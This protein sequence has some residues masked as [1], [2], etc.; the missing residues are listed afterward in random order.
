MMTNVKSDAAFQTI[1]DILQRS[2]GVIMFT[3]LQWIPEVSTLRR[4]FTSHPETYPLG[5]EK[6]VEVSAGWLDAVISKKEPFLAADLQ[7]LEE[8]FTDVQLIKSVGCGAVLNVPV[9]RDGQVVGVLALANTEGGYT[10]QSVS[11]AVDVVS[12][13]SASVARAFSIY[14]TTTPT[15]DPEL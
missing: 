13:H 4:V 15:K 3:A 2:P 9:L 14:P 1:F 5:A 7:A 12:G 8:V 11:A 10:A 6:T